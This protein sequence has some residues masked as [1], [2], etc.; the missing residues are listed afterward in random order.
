[1]CAGCMANVPIQNLYLFTEY[2]LCLK[3]GEIKIG[4]FSHSLWVYYYLGVPNDQNRS[5]L[6]LTGRC[7]FGTLWAGNNNT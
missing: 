1:M 3:A 6:P 5:Q 4:L 7:D 2:Y